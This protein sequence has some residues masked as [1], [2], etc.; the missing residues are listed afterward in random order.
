MGEEE[1]R[2]HQVELL[3]VVRVGPHHVADAV[4]DRA[5]AAE[6]SFLGGGGDHRLVGVDA[7]D[8]SVNEL[9]ELAH[10]IAAPHPTS[11]MRQFRLMPRRRSIEEVPSR[12]ASARMRSLARPSAPPAIT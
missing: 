5:E 10:D 7:H 11:M 12:V 1:S 8:D 6:A 4:V 2:V 9:D 3:D